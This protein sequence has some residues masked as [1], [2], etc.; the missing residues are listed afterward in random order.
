M[1][2][3]KY[4]TIIVLLLVFMY[5]ISTVRHIPPVDNE[6]P[7]NTK[8]YPHVSVT[9]EWETIID[10]EHI[11]GQD[12]VMDESHNLYVVGNILNSSENSYDVIV[13]KYD[14][15]GNMVWNVTW[16]GVL[17][18]YAYALDITKLLK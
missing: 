14:A 18:D 9:Y 7:L 1:R 13:I 5:G 8:D 6:A 11:I 16:G 2:G 4:K 12:F 17:D 3:Y 10:N 15:S